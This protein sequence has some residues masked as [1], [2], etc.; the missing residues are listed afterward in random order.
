MVKIVIHVTELISS[1]FHKVVTHASLVYFSRG[2]RDI[3]KADLPIWTSTKRTRRSEWKRANIHLTKESYG[4]VSPV[5]VVVVANQTKNEV[6]I[7]RWSFA[8]RSNI[9]RK[10]S[11]VIVTVGNDQQ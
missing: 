7:S 6:L 1:Y 9:A 4:A 10:V 3:E 5:V 2:G 11:S 8:P